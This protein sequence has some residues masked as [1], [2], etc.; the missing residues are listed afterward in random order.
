M[1]DGEFSIESNDEELIKAF[2]NIRQ[3][4]ENSSA[5]Y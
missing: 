3:S 1:A 4:I 5:S 2:E